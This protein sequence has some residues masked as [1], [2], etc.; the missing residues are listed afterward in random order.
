MGDS[1]SSP[2][3]RL[4]RQSPGTEQPASL[5][6]GHLGRTSLILL[7]LASFTPAVGM[8]I[9]P[10]VMV[11]AA[12]PTAWASSLLTAVVVICIGLCV[13][14]FARRFVATGSLYSYIGE[15][16]GPW[17][18]YLVAASLIAGYIVVLG[19]IAVS[20]GLFAGS[21]FGNLGWANAFEAGPQLLF[22]FLAVG[23]AGAVAY[24]GLDASVR[25]AIT[26]AIITIP[27]MIVITVASAAHTGLNFAVQFDM[28]ELN[29]ANTLQGVAAGAAWL[30]GF[31]SSAAM[32]AETKD[33]RK[34]IPL[35]VMAVPVVLGVV[36]LLCTFLQAPGLLLVTEQL[37]AGMSAPAALAH[38]AGLGTVFG[39]A[40][41][42]IL[43]I[44]GLS[45]LIGFVNYGARFLMTTSE[46]GLMPV[47]MSAIHPRFR[48]PH[49]AVLSVCFLG[50]VVVAAVLM[51]S[52]D[53]MTAYNTIAPFLLF[54]W[55]PSYA[56]IC[57]GAVVMTAREGGFR[58][59]LTFAA[60][61]GA[62]G[63]VWVYVSAVLNPP[64]APGD[65]ITWITV[66]VIAAIYAVLVL[67]VRAR[68]KWTPARPLAPKDKGHQSNSWQCL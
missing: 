63:V 33:P 5:N 59:L 53:I 8:A 18:R 21:F 30:V 36:Y 9:L 44:A 17:S 6:S 23:F 25:I 40:I 35:A 27:L 39:V 65:S 50:F 31:E 48:S 13:I 26:L 19:A 42:A 7:S 32:A 24:K 62:L 52:G 3:H 4:K 11:T 45:T 56:L 14:T 47:W 58:P 41:D 61:V 37:E 12:G 20:T 15:V 49:R 34:N 55:T 28:S 43:V 51:A 46:D 29:L 22:A 54:C 10:M 2:F 16:F 68:Q 1:F 64:P 38:A 66:L 57:V 60:V 67:G